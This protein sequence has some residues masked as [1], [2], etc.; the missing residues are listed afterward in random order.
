MKSSKLSFALRLLGVAFVFVCTVQMLHWP[1][2]PKP[3]T[4]LDWWQVR[5]M[6]RVGV[7]VGFPVLGAMFPLGRLGISS[8]VTSAHLHTLA[9]A[10]S[11]LL[12]W[13]SGRVGKK[14]PIEA[15][16]TTRGK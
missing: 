3:G 9:L 4:P 13:L 5:W 6:A 7:F 2:L 14:E 15:A 10:W 8:A 16:E 11:L 12:F 1:L